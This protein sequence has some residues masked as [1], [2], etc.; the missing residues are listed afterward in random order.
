MLV[1]AF[2]KWT[3]AEVNS[4]ELDIT[5]THVVS[6]AEKIRLLPRN[7]TENLRAQGT[8]TTL[9]TG[10]EVNQTDSGLEVILQ[11]SAGEKLVPL[12][13]PEG[14]NLV[15][16]LLDA[17]LALPMG[18]EFRETNPAPGIAE[19][20]MSQ[21][22]DS[23]IRLTISGEQNVPSAEVIPSQQNLVLR[24]T[25]E[26]T[27]QTEPDEEI[28]I[29]STRTEEPIS[30]VPRSV[31]VIEREEIEQ[32]EALSD[33]LPDILGQ[34][35]PGFGPP[36]QSASNRGQSLRGRQPQVLIDGIPTESNRRAFQ[37]LR[38]IDPNAI[39]RIEVIRGANAVFGAE[40][41]GGTINII[42]RD[43]IDEP[44]TASTSLTLGPRISLSDFSDSFGGEVSQF[45]AGGDEDVD[46]LLSLAYS[47]TGDTFDAEGDRIPVGRSQ[48]LDNLETF[49][50]LGKLGVN[51]TEEQRLQF[52]L[53]H[54][55]DVQDDPT[56]PDP[57][58]DDIEER[59]K[60]RSL[61]NGEI[62][63]DD[64]PGRKD[65]IASVRYTND[66]LLGSQ[67]QILG[68]YQQFLSRTIPQDNRDTFFNSVSRTEINTEKLGA[69]V[70]VDTPIIDELDLLWG[71]DYLNESVENP[72]TVFDPETFEDS[73][74]QEFDTVDELFFSPPYDVNS[75]GL[76]AQLRWDAQDWL[77]FSG[78]LRY[79]QIELAV[80]DY[81]LLD[82]P[83]LGTVEGGNI[84][85]DDVVF[86]LGTTV[87]LT[88]ELNLF[89]NF[90]QGF[91]A[92]DFGRILRFPPTGFISVENSIDI[93]EPV[94]IDS[95]EL[96][97]RGE[98]D[99]IQFSVAGFYT[100]SEF[101][102]NVRQS[103]D[104][105]F[106]VLER[107]PTR[108][109]G[110]EAALD[111]QPADAWQLGTSFSWTEGE[112]NPE[113]DGEDDYIA[114]SSLDIQPLK[115]TAYVE[116][117]TLPRWRNR[118]QLLV[119]GSRDRAFEDGVDELDIDSYATFD[120]I[121]SLNLGRGTLTL[122]IQNLL[123]KQYF[124]VDSQ[125]QDENSENAAALGRTFSLGYRFN[126]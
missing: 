40:A 117:L 91:S 52:A 18:D 87:D 30:R 94:K 75:L 86:N 24:V 50:V 98:W 14:N 9:V 22:D 41:A 4:I 43:F 44:F 115:V 93:T 78:G 74:G 63:I 88:D 100:E 105:A 16:D 27:A 69:R 1:A 71:A 32:Q 72:L 73:G 62:E 5:S 35:V 23:S 126:W 48:G 118:L 2:P 7:T 110:F 47:Q 125:V 36:S 25:P 46:Y 90:S 111:Y 28:E 55:S 54:F 102:E 38:S 64:S 84:D 37:N 29:I 76:F 116:N 112:S 53:N 26:A 92:T 79:E 96:G 104:G 21:L 89:A 120:F 58:L 10:V 34:T 42:T 12:I 56:L 31:T 59:V 97:L 15:I 11:T 70:Q 85:I 113:D 121:S 61:D 80:D 123:D 57:A 13:L 103:D 45:L 95:Y 107:S 17:T 122:G 8:G 49:N 119:V 106:L 39:E 114:L 51:I 124:P 68:F 60:A 19:I 108:T 77:S 6:E 109:Y 99:K 20:A 67:V 83:G 33:N 81:S 66:D 101:G 3:F 65:T 82:T